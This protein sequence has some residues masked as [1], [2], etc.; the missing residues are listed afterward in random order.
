MISI[1]VKHL[2]KVV[3][4]MELVKYYNFKEYTP[5]IQ[6]NEFLPYWELVQIWFILVYILKLTNLDNLTV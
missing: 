5:P 4:C 6:Q 1:Q 2:D 3:Q